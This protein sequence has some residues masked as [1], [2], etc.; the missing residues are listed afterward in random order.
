MGPDYTYCDSEADWPSKVSSGTT[1]FTTV[2]LLIIEGYVVACLIKKRNLL[3]DRQLTRMA[4]RVV[5]FSILGAIG[6]GLGF[7]YVLYSIPGASFDV[8][9]AALP[10]GGFLIFGTQDDL[11]NVWMFWRKPQ[12]EESQDVKASRGSTSKV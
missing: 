12:P 1:I 8:I 3:K 7:A 11:L 5:V 6:L 9:M 2:F 10:V 4:I